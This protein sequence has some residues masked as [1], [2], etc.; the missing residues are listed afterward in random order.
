MSAPIF[1]AADLLNY[2]PRKAV[3]SRR[4]LVT[5]EVT[6]DIKHFLAVW[7]RPPADDPKWS[8]PL[9][10]PGEVTVLTVLLEL[11]A[12]GFVQDIEQVTG[13]FLVRMKDREAVV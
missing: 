1:V 12:K 2:V 5:V 6:E 10:K 8:D 4:T 11:E 7:P 9:R 13:G 3:L